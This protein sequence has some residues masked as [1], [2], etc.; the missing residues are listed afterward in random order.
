[1]IVTVL[2]SGGVL[3]RAAIRAERLLIAVR[4]PWTANMPKNRNAIA[5]L[6]Q[7]VGVSEIS[8]RAGRPAVKGI[9]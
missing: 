3:R 7:I 9:V 8:S 1:L 6:I 4:K 2:V 5:A